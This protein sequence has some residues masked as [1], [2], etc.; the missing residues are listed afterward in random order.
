MYWTI[1][2][3]PLFS[4]FFKQY[5]H[6]H[7]KYAFQI[8]VLLYCIT[9]PCAILLLPYILWCLVG[10]EELPTELRQRKT[11][12]KSCTD[13]SHHRTLLVLEL[14]SKVKEETV[15]WLAA[16]ICGSQSDGG[17]A[18]VVRKC[19]NENKKVQFPINYLISFWIDLIL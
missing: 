15:D 2:E 8:F 13:T 10:V 14:S 12:G 9:W 11:D 17:A 7:F 6:L 3:Q 16:K 19:K 5:K 4:W 1:N 18:L